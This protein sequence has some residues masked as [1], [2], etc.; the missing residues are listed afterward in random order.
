MSG[1]LTGHFRRLFLEILLALDAGNGILAQGM[2]ATEN[3]GLLGER[4]RPFQSARLIERCSDYL[5]LRRK[6]RDWIDLLKV[7]SIFLLRQ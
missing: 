6:Y 3:Q 2:A 7:D 1:F 5:E 4:P